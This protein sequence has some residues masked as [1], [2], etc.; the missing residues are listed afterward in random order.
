M[1]IHHSKQSLWVTKLLCKI[2]G[3]KI[4]DKIKEYLVN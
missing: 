4:K 2:D 1:V 3:Y